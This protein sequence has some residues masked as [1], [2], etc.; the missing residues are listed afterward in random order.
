[1]TM[2]A[3][4]LPDRTLCVSISPSAARRIDR[5]GRRRKVATV[6]GQ[7]GFQVAFGVNFR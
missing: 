6:D 1:M 3:L 4:S 2:A 5:F 7:K